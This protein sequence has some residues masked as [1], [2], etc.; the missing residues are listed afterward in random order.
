L[1]QLFGFDPVAIRGPKV[2]PFV[3][4]AKSLYWFLEDPVGVIMKLR[5]QGDVVALVD[6]SPAVVFV[7]GAERNREILTNPGIFRHD[8][9]LFRGPPGSAMDKM[10]FSTVTI[11]GDT[12]RRHRKLMQPAFQKSALDG[13]AA[14]IVATTRTMLDVW[15]IGTVSDM[16]G[17]CRDAALAMAMKCLY[18]LDVS[19][20]AHELGHLASE[21]VKNVSEPTTILLPFDLPG[22]TYRKTLQLGDAALKRLGGLIEQKRRMGG[23]Q[24][25]AMALL[26]S[27]QDDEEKPLSDDELV[28]EAAS[29]FIAGHETT[30]MTLTWT[31]LLLERHP[32]ILSTLMAELETVL[33]GRD[34]EPE[35]IPQ[36]VVLDRVIKESMRIITAVPLLFMRVCAES[37]TVG[38]HAVPKN[39]NIILSPLATHHD[40][41]LY[42]EPKRFLPDRWIDMKPAPYA[43]LPFGAGPRICVGMLFAE[44]AL[45]LMLPMILQRFQFSIPRGTRVDRLTRANIL[46]PRHGLPMFIERRSTRAIK[47]APIVGEIHEVLDC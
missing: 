6:H 34:P 20:E 21:W 35:D 39:S 37:T 23:E 2:L 46:K 10:R 22:T 4:L 26:M 43:Y 41:Q 40:P 27:A 14:D 13:Y 17:L 9:T 30:A 3:G 12:H 33:G 42:P 24:R 47:P 11:N 16:D 29:L 18:G 36:M 5:Q 8:E 7:F 31:L 32:E 25:D 15:K 38:G 44:R 28:A 1:P 45:R 19:K